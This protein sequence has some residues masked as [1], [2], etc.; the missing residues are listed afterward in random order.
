MAL[1]E[2]MILLNIWIFQK[3]QWPKIL[4]GTMSIQ[5]TINLIVLLELYIQVIIYLKIEQK[6]L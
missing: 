4:L 5:Q 2:K 6:E 1:Q 3:I